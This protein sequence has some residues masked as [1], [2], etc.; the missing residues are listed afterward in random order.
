M[1]SV[2]QQIIEGVAQNGWF[3]VTYVPG[4][5]DSEEWFTYTVGSDQDRRLAG[6]HLLCASTGSGR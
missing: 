4:L 1:N 5:G 6:A 3:A 2:E